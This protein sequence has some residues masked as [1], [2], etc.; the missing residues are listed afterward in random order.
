MKDIISVL[1]EYNLTIST[2][3]S[4][5]A[6]L[7]AAQICNISGASNYFKGGVVSYTKDAK[8]SLLGIELS[9]IQKYC[10]YSFEVAQKMAES[11]KKRTNSDVAI[12]I[13]GVAG[14]GNDENVKAGTMYYGFVIKD[15]IFTEV[16]CFTGNRNEVRDEASTYAINR[17]IELIEG[18]I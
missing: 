2:A 1:K 11:V 6:G 13:S 12:S 4:A 7:I 14:P 16:K 10:V 15:K 18:N 5:T 3:E 8:E 9:Y 17:C